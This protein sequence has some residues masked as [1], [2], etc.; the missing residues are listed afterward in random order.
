W[1]QAFPEPLFHGDFHCLEQRVLK[2]KHLKMSVAHPASNRIFDAIAFN[3]D[4]AQWPNEARKVRLAY[5][6]DI[7]EFRGTRSLQLRVEYMEPLD[8]K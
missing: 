6:L 1:G 4:R 5:R 7:N 2:E 8:A 3:V